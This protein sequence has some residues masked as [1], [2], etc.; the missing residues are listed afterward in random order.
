MKSK[1]FIHILILIVTAISFSSCSLFGD[2]D[3]SPTEPIGGD[4]TPM[5]A[6]GNTFDIFGIPGTSNTS[7]EVISQDGANAT[8]QATT[9]LTNSTAL[10]LAEQSPAWEVSGN[11]VTGTGK[12][13]ITTEGVQTYTSDGTPFTLVEY[14]A[15]E[16]DTYELNR[17]SSDLVRTVTHVSE[18]DDYSWGFLL[19]KTVQVEETG[20]VTPGVSR[21]KYIANHRFGI[22]GMEVY[23]E[24]GSSYFLDVYSAANNE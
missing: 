10:G 16:G 7:V 5:G 17:E 24:D 14:D 13:R 18:D 20:L 8:I 12:F 9:T 6:V 22:V 11:S 21:V 3:P 4:P 15:R 23:F 19:I 2:D 1:E